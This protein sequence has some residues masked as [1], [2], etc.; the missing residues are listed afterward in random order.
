MTPFLLKEKLST[1]KIKLK[2]LL[3]ITSNIQKIISIHKAFSQKF[4]IPSN[5]ADDFSN[6]DSLWNTVTN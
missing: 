1:I 3:S 4:H 2:L 6:S 5:K